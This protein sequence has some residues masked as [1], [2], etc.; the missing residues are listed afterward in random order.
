MLLSVASTA[1]QL[2]AYRA[3]RNQTKFVEK[4]TTAKLV[5][6]FRFLISVVAQVVPLWKATF[7]GHVCKK[8]VTSVSV[9]LKSLPTNCLEKKA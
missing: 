8:P 4:G 9:Y 1:S 5:K 3:S 2:T 6:G 7:Y